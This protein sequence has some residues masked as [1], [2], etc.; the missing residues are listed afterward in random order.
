ML[1]LDPKA[2]ISQML[3]L[4]PSQRTENWGLKPK[5]TQSISYHRQVAASHLNL[6]QTLLS[7]MIIQ[8]EKDVWKVKKNKGQMRMFVVVLI[9]PPG[10]ENSRSWT[11]VSTSTLKES[12][13]I[14]VWF[15]FTMWKKKKKGMGEWWKDSMYM[16][17]NI[18]IIMHNVLNKTFKL[19]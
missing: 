14:L 13:E 11:A 19:Y 16:R 17:W 4:N 12:L 7:P 6:A 8:V 10:C 9:Q 2:P 15:Y 5:V 3:R 1:L 18:S